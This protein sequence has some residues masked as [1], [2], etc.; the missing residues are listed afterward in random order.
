MAITSMENRILQ[1]IFRLAIKADNGFII[2][3]N[4][5]PDTGKA[6]CPCNS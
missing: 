1:A 6:S 2:M 3:N 5:W 4:R